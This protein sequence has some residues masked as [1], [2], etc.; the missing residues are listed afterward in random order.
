MH[1]FSSVSLT[2]PVIVASSSSIE[3]PKLLDEFNDIPKFSFVRE[4]PSLL[5]LPVD[6]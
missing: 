2:V 4:S 5:S 6:C 3:I 1:V